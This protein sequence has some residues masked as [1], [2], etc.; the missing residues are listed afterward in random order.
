ML[1]NHHILWT[2]QASYRLS[3]IASTA[4]II[5]LDTHILLLP[6]LTEDQGNELRLKHHV[7]ILPSSGR[8]N[9]GAVTKA[10]VEYVAEAIAKVVAK[11]WEC[12]DI[13]GAWIEDLRHELGDVSENLD[14]RPECTNK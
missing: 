6:D 2:K 7:Y 9:V 3:H 1:M 14:F 8:I 13:F 12:N 4:R 5:V 10:N 11:N